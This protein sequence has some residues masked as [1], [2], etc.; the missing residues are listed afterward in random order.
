MRDMFHG[1]TSFNQDIG[2]WD[3][4]AVRKM[5]YMFKNAASFN[6]ELTSWAP[7]LSGT[8]GRSCVEFAVGATAW[9]DNWTP[10]NGSPNPLN[11]NPPLSQALLTAGCGEQQ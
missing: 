6:Q 1:A 3:V 7:S 10:I 2:G 8:D 5:D 9:L 11:D 4:S